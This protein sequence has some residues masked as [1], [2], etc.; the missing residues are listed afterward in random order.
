MAAIYVCIFV[1]EEGEKLTEK[2]TARV[3]KVGEIIRISYVDT[4]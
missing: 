2:V 1:N 4:L 3:P